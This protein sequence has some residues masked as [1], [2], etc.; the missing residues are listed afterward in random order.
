MKQDSARSKEQFD[1][2][3]AEAVAGAAEM[4]EA[5]AQVRKD[6]AAKGI[7]YNVAGPLGL[8]MSSLHA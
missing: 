6:I 7:P 4:K 2:K 1:T 8:S 5:Y 3:L